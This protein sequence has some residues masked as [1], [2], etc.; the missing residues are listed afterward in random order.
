MS[1]WGG[2]ERE[3]KIYIVSIHELATETVDYRF[4]HGMGFLELGNFNAG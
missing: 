4:D 1:I 2:G 3:S